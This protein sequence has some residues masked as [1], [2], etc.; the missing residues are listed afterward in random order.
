MG[1]NKNE[2]IKYLKDN[3]LI[4]EAKIMKNRYLRLVF[5]VIAFT[6]FQHASFA[7][8]S[9]APIAKTFRVGIFAPLYLD[10]VFSLEGKFKYKGIPH[11]ISP[12]VDFINGAELALDSLRT[13][14]S[15]IEAYIYDTKSYISPVDKLIN[16]RKLDKLD[17]IIGSVK[18]QEYK[19]LAAFALKRNIPFISATYPNDGGITA[20]PFLVVVNSTLKAHCEAIYS[21]VLQNH[22]TDKVFLV[23]KKG[24]QEDKVA[25]Y[26]N[27]INKPD[28]KPLL[29]IET[30]NVDNTITAD[31]LAKK[32]DSNYQC[33]II[34]G[35]LDENF[36]KDLTT[37][38]YELSEHYT[39]TLV[40][41]PNWDGFK[42]LTKK[43]AF[44]NFPIYFTTPYYNDKTDDFSRTVT[45]GYATKYKGIAGDMVFKGF[46]CTYLFTKL[47]I[48]H[49]Y[50]FMSQLNDPNYKV[51]SNYN[52]RPVMSN[53]VDSIPDYFE[54]KHL[55]FIRI[56]NGGVSKAW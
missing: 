1:I 16:A 37:A 19:Q 32:L 40:G 21:F 52:F 27:M 41:M 46:E 42:S 18:D 55:Y 14:T 47:L 31:I 51:F 56:I 9:T 11:F 36:A 22:G 8:A 3:L 49:P 54:N 10:S 33:I 34:G 17:L 45:D 50:D 48:A 28:G 43:D 6:S 23:R 25:E 38:C 44:E 53:K 30:I 13:D 26:F 15:K 35:S 7:Q 12:A 4:T 39:T 2:L 24:F 20:N 5:I 29:N